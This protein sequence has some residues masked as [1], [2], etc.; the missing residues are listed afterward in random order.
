MVNIRSDFSEDSG[1]SPMSSINPKML[2]SLQFLSF[3]FLLFY[4]NLCEI[5]LLG[6]YVEMCGYMSIK[7]DKTF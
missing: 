6:N 4:F 5:D 7:S 3:S 1:E 2:T